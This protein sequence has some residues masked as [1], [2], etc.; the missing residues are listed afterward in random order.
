MSTINIYSVRNAL[1][2]EGWQLV[3]EI[4]KNLK[5]PLDMKCPAGHL[6]S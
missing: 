4:Y 2:S 5:T 3:S 1:E 6:Q